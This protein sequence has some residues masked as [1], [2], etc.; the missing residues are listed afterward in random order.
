M[1]RAIKKISWIKVLY[2]MRIMASILL[3]ILLILLIPNILSCG[4]E[5]TVF[6]IFYIIF[7]G[8]NFYTILSKKKSF[9]QSFSYNLLNIG[10]SVYTFFIWARVYLDKRIN[11]PLIYEI[12]LSYFKNNYLI[13]STI[14]LGI[15]FHSLI[16][17]SEK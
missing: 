11:L 15:V 8:F 12:N 6:I 3:M 7:T 14:I 4:W 9:Q 2:Y 5:G 17:N 16:L 13:L 1:K 10:L